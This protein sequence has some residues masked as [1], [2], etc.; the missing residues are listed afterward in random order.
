MNWFIGR[1]GIYIEPDLE[2]S[3]TYIK[4]GEIRNCAE[5][6]KCTYM[7]RSELGHANSKMLTEDEHK[8]NIYNLVGN[9]IAQ[10]QLAD[11]INQVHATNLVYNSVSVNAYA[12]ERKAEL[13][14]F[15]GTIIAGIYEGILNCK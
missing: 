2:Y 7:C 3:D 1:N 6:G 5:N 13:G 9:P 8:G 11:Y 14:E 4:E 10:A 12:K 15:L